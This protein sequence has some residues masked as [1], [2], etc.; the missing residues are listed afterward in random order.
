MREEPQSSAAP[1][2]A[3]PTGAWRRT[4]LI[5]L[6]MCFLSELVGFVSL[7]LLGRHWCELVKSQFTEA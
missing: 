3:R 5:T 6:V 1:P 7:F 4:P 2:E